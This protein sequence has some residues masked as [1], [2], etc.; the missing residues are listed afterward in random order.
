[1]DQTRVPE[2]IGGPWDGDAVQAAVG[3]LRVPGTHGGYYWWNGRNYIWIVNPPPTVPACSS[4]D[5]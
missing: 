2:Y 1:M 4:N 5:E 3:D